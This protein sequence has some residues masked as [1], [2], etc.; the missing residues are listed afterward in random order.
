MKH[1]WKQLVSSFERNSDAMKLADIRMKSMQIMEI[2]DKE[3]LSTKWIKS[4]NPAS[5]DGSN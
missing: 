5:L 3:L 1:I 2:T 4:E